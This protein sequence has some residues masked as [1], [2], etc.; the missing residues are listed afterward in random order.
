MFC[1]TVWLVVISSLFLE[2]FSQQLSVKGRMHCS[3]LTILQQ[4]RSSLFE[5]QVES[6]APYQRHRFWI[7]SNFCLC[8]LLSTVRLVPAYSMYG[9]VTVL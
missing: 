9:L 7:T 6:T 1:F 2:A 3:T 5:I 8:I 4:K